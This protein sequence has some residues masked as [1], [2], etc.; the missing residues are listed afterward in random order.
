MLD[1][2]S[3]FQQQSIGGNALALNMTRSNDTL[4]NEMTKLTELNAMQSSNQ[5]SQM[6]FFLNWQKIYRV[7]QK[8]LF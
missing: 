5:S 6:V 8:G 3:A 4:E 1:R 2:S 7:I